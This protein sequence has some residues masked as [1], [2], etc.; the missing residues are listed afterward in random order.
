[1]KKVKKSQIRKQKKK[2]KG[3]LSKGIIEAKK[4]KENE[5]TFNKKNEVIL[6]LFLV[7]NY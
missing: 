6:I 4:E 5:E 1:M 2:K 3:K 7:K